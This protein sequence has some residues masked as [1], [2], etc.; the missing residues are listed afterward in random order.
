MTNRGLPLAFG[1]LGIEGAGEPMEGEE[2]VGTEDGA[3]HDLSSC[4]YVMI[5]CG[6]DSKA[7][8]NMS[9]RE[10]SRHER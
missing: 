1:R 4:W 3:S 8:L 10:Q 2:E 6:Q 7:Q 9:V 5:E